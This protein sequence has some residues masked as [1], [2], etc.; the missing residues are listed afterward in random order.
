NSSPSRTSQTAHWSLEWH[1]SRNR[2]H[3][4]DVL[5]VSH[6]KTSALHDF[7]R[8]RLL[9]PWKILHPEPIS[10]RPAQSE[11]R[12]LCWESLAQR[13]HWHVRYDSLRQPIQLT[14][15]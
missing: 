14:R 8:R 13:L 11:V 15:K 4:P 12:Q 6:S 9:R 10:F 7:L 1:P 2:R 5:A 3:T